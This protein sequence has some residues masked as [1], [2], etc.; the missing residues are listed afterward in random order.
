M[1]LCSRPYV[2]HAPLICLLDLITRM[3]FDLKIRENTNFHS[4][5]LHKHKI[6]M[7]HGGMQVPNFPP[8]RYRKTERPSSCPIVHCF[9]I[10]FCLL[11]FP[12]DCS[13]SAVPC[14]HTFEGLNSEGQEYNNLTVSNVKTK[15][16]CHVVTTRVN[17]FY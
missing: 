7:Q 16:V 17:S 13:S 14:R 9:Q 12:P 8:T 11:L 3:T 5:A 2:L 6:F 10:S 4:P 15:L 1:H